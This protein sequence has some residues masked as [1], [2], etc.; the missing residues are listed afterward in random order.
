[1]FY[2]VLSRAACIVAEPLI[3]NQATV[4]RHCH[5]LPA[6][7]IYMAYAGKKISN[8]LSGQDIFFIQTH[9]DTNGSLLE[10]QTV[11]H[12]QSQEPPAHYHPL[13]SEKFT[14]LS[15]R[16]N[17]K[18]NNILTILQTGDSVLVPANTSHAMWNAH[19]EPT[20][21]NWRTE[22]AMQTEYFFET[23]FGV[24][25]DGKSTASGMPNV[26]QISLLMKSYSNIIRLARPSYLVQKIIFSLLR[27]VA[28]LL[29]YKSNY[30]RYIN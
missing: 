7:T 6:F 3:L 19:K 22:P 14:V 17:I 5:I 4:K 20:I 11:Y 12:A 13:Q 16:L 24:A 29:G 25:A 9:N 23:V 28:L 2:K 26:L 15:G 1:M 8:P 27:P 10:M 18:I 30:E 21:V